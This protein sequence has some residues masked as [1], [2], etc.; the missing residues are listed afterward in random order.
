MGFCNSERCAGE[1]RTGRGQNG[2]EQTKTGLGKFERGGQVGKG[3]GKWK[4]AK[5][6]QNGLGLV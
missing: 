2:M 3:R 5:T 4:R 1:F 6:G